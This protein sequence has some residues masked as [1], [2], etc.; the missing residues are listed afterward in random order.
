MFVQDWERQIIKVAESPVFGGYDQVMA[1][2][3]ADVL[4][5]IELKNDEM[6]AKIAANKK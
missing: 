2:P 5:Y 1:P 3:L 4:S 6:R